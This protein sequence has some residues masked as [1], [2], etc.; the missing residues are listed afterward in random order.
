MSSGKEVEITDLLVEAEYEIL[1]VAAGLVSVPG[2]QGDRGETGPAGPIGPAGRD[3]VDGLPGRDGVDGLP[4]R[5][6]VDGLPGRDGRD[7]LDGLDGQRGPAGADGLNGVNGADGKDGAQ[8]LP[9]IPGSK[10]DKGDPGANGRDGVDGAA[11]EPGA[12]GPV[13][14]AGADGPAGAKG[15]I[16][17]TGAKGDA[18]T[19]GEAGADGQQGPIGPKGDTG[20][21]GATGPKGDAGAAGAKGDTGATGAAGTNGTNGTNGQGVPTG[22]AAGQVLSKVNATDYNTTWVTPAS[23]G[24]AANG[25]PTG[26]TTN[27]IL[28]KTSATDYAASWQTKTFLAT[29]GTG[30]EVQYRNGAALAGASKVSVHTDGNLIFGGDA[31]VRGANIANRSHLSVSSQYALQ[32]QFPLGVSTGFSTQ[33]EWQAHGETLSVHTKAFDPAYQGTA[34]AVPMSPTAQLCEPQITYETAAAASSIASLTCLNPV[35]K[36][37]TTNV[38]GFFVSLRLRIPAWTAGQRWFVGLTDNPNAPVDQDPSGIT[39]FMGFGVNSADSNLQYMVR[40]TG[41]LT[42]NDLNMPAAVGNNLYTFMFFCPV[43]SSNITATVINDVYS[44]GGSS[45]A[46]SGTKLYLKAW[47]GTGS[48]TTK[49]SISFSRGY[50]EHIYYTF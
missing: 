21:P 9:G 12:T 42:K 14:P 3:G 35:M 28:T 37:T 16:G 45:T 49:A 38:A 4:G 17:A 20:S 43:D 46:V 47:I 11:G 32:S 41:T 39:N 15:D 33:R 13:G 40:S 48:T 36:P 24:S 26:G 30:R 1:E 10:G 50:M 29:N 22:G 7:G 18:G 25:L 19:P 34:V 2:P 8:G 5:N 31:V 6:G 27:Q 23:S 44:M